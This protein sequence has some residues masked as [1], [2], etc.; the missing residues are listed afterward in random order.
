MASSGT[1]TRVESETKAERQLRPLSVSTLHE[2]KFPVESETKAERQ[3]RLSL[4]TLLRNLLVS[5]HVES[6]AEA[7]RQLRLERNLNGIRTKVI[8]P[9]ESETKA[10]R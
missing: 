2:W 7:E 9:V 10:E 8:R 6:E 3:L 5:K 1:S 4:G